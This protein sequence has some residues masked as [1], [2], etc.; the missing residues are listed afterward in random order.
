MYIK[1]GL[2]KF[3][4]LIFSII[5]TSRA[6]N[7][8]PDY[9]DKAKQFITIN[10]D[11]SNFYN[12]LAMLIAKQN[13][14]PF[15]EQLAYIQRGNILFY[16]NKFD[17]SIFYYLKAHEINK[18]LNNNHY[19]VQNYSD[20]A[21]VYSNINKEFLV[22][23]SKW[24]KKAEVI[25]TN[26]ADSTKAYYYKTAG[27]IYLRQEKPDLA[28]KYF[29]K[30]LALSDIDLKTGHASLLNNIGFCYQ[31]QNMLNLAEVFIKRSIDSCEKYAFYRVKGIAMVN[32]A[33]N[34]SL[35]F[36]PIESNNIA[37]EA[38]PIL[39]SKS[40]MPALIELYGL[41]TRNFTMLSERDSIIKFQKLYYTTKDSIFNEST[42]QQLGN[43]EKTLE[44]QNKNLQ[45]E[46]SMNL[47][48]SAKKQTKLY[49]IIAGLIGML[50]I[51][52]SV[53][54]YLLYKR[55]KLLY[56]QKEVIQNSLKEKVSL[57][58]EI[59]HRV[60][61]NLQLVSS[62][63]ELQLK[64]LKDEKSIQV[65]NESKNRINSMLLLH[66]RLYQNEKIAFVNTFEYLETLLPSIIKS[67]AIFNKVNIINRSEP[68]KLYLDTAVPLALIINEI[69]T[70]SLK[71]AFD[72]TINP[73]IEIDLFVKN[74]ELVLMVKDNGSGFPDVDKVK[75]KSFGFKLI[76]SMCRQL[77]ATFEIENNNGAL[78]TI[79]IKNYRLYE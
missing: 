76:N 33:K 65:V 18:T 34:K 23:A 42:K 77:D 30:Q 35:A 69:V 12:K 21:F 40:A 75:V 19:L 78:T 15:Q 20:I 26:A 6:Q 3:C 62:L 8:F 61:N 39:K 66:Q 11:S 54:G 55:N 14:S 51:F 28:L 36:K 38:I 22:I 67:I 25:I 29:L 9:F 24:L 45:I 16:T 58:S 10:Y 46:N 52:I 43:I 49:A 50:F 17:S 63:I 27:V 4:F 2:Y 41:M 60:K 7:L 74:H 73:T 68:I 13:K 32:L 53:L 1:F 48:N 47:V 79:R 31:K 5:G 64:S 70:N 57:L 59:H 56:L 37:A 72:N 71:Y 44:V